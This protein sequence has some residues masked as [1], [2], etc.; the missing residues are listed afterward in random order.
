MRKNQTRILYGKELAELTKDYTKKAIKREGYQPVLGIITVDGGNSASK[1]YLKNKLAVAK[2]CGVEVKHY[3]AEV[4]NLKET[5]A[6]A[7]E[8][9]TSIMIQKPTGIEYPQQEQMFFNTI[10]QYK[11]V[12]VMGYMAKGAFYANGGLAPCTAI[13]VMRLLEFYHIDLK[14]E[15]V[16]II[17]RS[18][19]VGKPLAEI[20]LN[21]DATVTVCHSK[22][23]AKMLKKICKKADIII[24][25]AGAPKLLTRDMVKKD[26]V[27]IDVSINRDENGNLC[28]DADF[29]NL[30]GKVAAI[31]PVPGGVGAVT[32]AELMYSVYA[33]CM[34]Q[35]IV[36]L[37]DERLRD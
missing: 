14:G 19:A 31:S 35:E 23:P 28:G 9:C 6:Q 21:H 18:N 15:N 7:I 36:R 27:I 2:E 10:P 12:D 17:S 34:M 25:A 11:D 4:K 13:S 3:S 32:T 24:T 1:V 37:N 8:E 16:V 20:C 30:L 29:K 22:T 26:S 33:N 5:M